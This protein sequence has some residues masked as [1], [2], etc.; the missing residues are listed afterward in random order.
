MKRVDVNWTALAEKL[1]DDLQHHIQEEEERVFPA[2]QKLFTRQDAI[3]IGA[4]FE[5]MKPV[6]RERSMVGTTVDLF[7]NLFRK[8]VA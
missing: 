1:R 7:A 3:S 5:S 2:A 8:K 4:A 6:I